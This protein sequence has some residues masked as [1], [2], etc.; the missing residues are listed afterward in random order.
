MNEPSSS[1]LAFLARDRSFMRR[2]ACEGEASDLFFPTGQIARGSYGPGKAVCA[3]CPVSSDCLS[4][5][6]EGESESAASWPGLW[7]GLTP[8]ERR[9][10]RRALAGTSESARPMARER[11][12][13]A[14]GS[15]DA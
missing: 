3:T 13:A 1:L 12:G 9:S 7:G 14:V 15:F 5:A 4:Y 11:T 2:A 10:L 6:L 8:T